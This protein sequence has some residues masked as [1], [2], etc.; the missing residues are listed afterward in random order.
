MASDGHGPALLRHGAGRD[1]RSNHLASI[2]VTP[3]TRQTGARADWQTIYDY[4]G[5]G[6]LPPGTRVTS[7]GK[8]I[9]P[10]V[11][12]DQSG[13][14]FAFPDLPDNPESSSI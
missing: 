3:L 11:R 9:D 5:G 2:M 1:Y 6:A 4:A 8:W 12:Q 10:I 7:A 13:V 14:T